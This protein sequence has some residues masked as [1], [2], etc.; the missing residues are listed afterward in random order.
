MKGLGE[1]YIRVLPYER[2]GRKVHQSVT[3]KVG[4]KGTSEC[5]LMKGLGERY[6]RVL[7]Y[8]RVGRKIH[9]SV[10]L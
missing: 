1:R 7:P 3:L 4:E 10:T 2:F 8:E 9:Q 6:I 5:Y